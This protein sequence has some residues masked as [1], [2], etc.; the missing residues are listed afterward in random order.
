MARQDF[1]EHLPS[2]FYI[3]SFNDNDVDD[4]GDD[5][6]DDDDAFKSQAYSR[7]LGPDMQPNSPT[8]RQNPLKHHSNQ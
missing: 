3:P 5:D 2:T 6:D 1:W 7:L 8:R 4:D